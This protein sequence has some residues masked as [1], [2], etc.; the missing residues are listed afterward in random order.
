MPR[1]SARSRRGCFP[2]FQRGLAAVPRSA[3]A[4]VFCASLVPPLLGAGGSAEAQEVLVSNLNSATSPSVRLGAA[5]DSKDAVQLFTTGTNTGGYTLN[6]SEGDVDNDPV[7]YTAPMDTHARSTAARQARRSAMRS[8]RTRSPTRTPATPRQLGP[9]RRD[10]R[11]TL[12][13]FALAVLAVLATLAPEPAA[14]QTKPPAPTNLTAAAGDG[15][16]ALGWTTPGDGGSAII[17]HQYREKVGAGSYGGWSDIPNS[18]ARGA[19]ATGYR[20]PS[21]T[22]GTTYSYQV[23]AVNGGE[24]ERPVQRGQRDADGGGDQAAGADESDGGGR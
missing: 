17:R 5:T 16:V 19:N 9:C 20:V 2:F 7:T 14:A 8:R 11:P 6:T 10:A 12:V 23:R 22:N 4:W 24:R 3:A 13:A 15:S 18:G 21:R 1:L